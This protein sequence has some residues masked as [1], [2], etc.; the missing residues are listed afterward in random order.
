MS[1]IIK[2]QSISEYNHLR[3]LPTVHPMV[4]VFDL[5]SVPRLPSGNYNMNLYAVFFKEI[6]CGELRYGRNLY[7]YQEGTL[8]FLAPA[9]VI[10][11][12]P[13]AQE[14]EPKGMALLFHA[15]LIKGTALG[16]AIHEYS[17]FSYD[18]NEALHISE[19]ENSI[20]LDC[21]D[22][23]SMEMMHAIDRHTRRL[24]SA[25][26]DLLLQYCNRFY[27]RQFITRENANQGIIEKFEVVLKDYFSSDMPKMQGLPTVAYLAGK[28]NLSPNYLGD[29]IKKE[30]GMSPIEHIHAR[31]IDLAKEKIFD[32]EASISHIA[33][34][35]GFTYPQHFSRIFKQ[36]V[37]MSPLEYRSI[38]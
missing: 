32:P 30:T 27:E 22:K 20:V 28:L 26:I 31:V 33:Y 10:G 35:L 23:I 25:N 5:S 9:Q 21:F 14:M 3:G 12:P 34:E 16:K 15:D 19:S 37:G 17:F 29:L 4:T 6:K 13:H 38:D 7:D 36:K 11:V 2:I 8:M 1:E 18:V 24:I